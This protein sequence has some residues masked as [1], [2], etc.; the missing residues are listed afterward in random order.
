MIPLAFPVNMLHQ[1]VRRYR[2]KTKHEGYFTENFSVK[3][4]EIQN[5]KWCSILC[6]VHLLAILYFILMI[7]FAKVTYIFLSWLN[8]Q[9]Q[10][11]ELANVIVI[12]FIIGFIMF[13]LP[14]VPGVPVYI[15]GGIILASR[16]A[17]EPLGFWGG[18]VVAIFV[19]Y[20]LKLTAVCGQWSIGVWLGQSI[21]VQKMVGVDQVAIRAIE[22]ILRRPGL[23]LPKV[24]VLVGGPDWPTSVLCGILRIKLSQAVLGT[25]PCIVVATPCVLVGA[26]LLKAG[27][28]ST[29]GSWS[30]IAGATLMVASLGQGGAG[31][32][33]AYF[34]SQVAAEKGEELAKPRPEHRPIEELTKKEQAAV[35]A[36]ERAT[37]WDKVPLWRK[38]LLVISTTLQVGAWA[39]F[40]FQ[41]KTC[42]R[43]FSLT[44][45]IEDPYDKN[46]LE[47]DAVNIVKPMGWVALGM[48]AL[49]CV[50]F[51][52]FKM[53]AGAAG[54]NELSV[55][56]R[57]EVQEAEKIV[58]VPVEVEKIVEKVVEVPVKK[59]IEV[60]VPIE[61]DVEMGIAIEVPVE[62]IKIREVEKIVPQEV[63]VEK[64]VKE[65]VQV[66]VEKIGKEE[67][68]VEKIVEK[69]V[70]VPVEKVVMEELPME[71]SEVTS[72]PRYA[73]EEFDALERE[74]ATEKGQQD[75]S[76]SCE[77][78]DDPRASKDRQD[79][80]GYNSEP[81]MN[82]SRFVVNLSIWTWWRKSDE[83]ETKPAPLP[84][85]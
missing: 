19:G 80:G 72:A 43:P 30:A 47:G 75:S 14:P 65:E 57:Q 82:L 59:V 2:S 76:A 22:D 42:F 36:Y 16:A 49:A 4:K 55:Y 81:L 78:V 23:S 45:K 6:K 74:I 56:Q 21:S 67:V 64:I 9:L 3:L 63:I 73:Q 52:V 79:E 61:K 34:M 26:F 33:A 51:K 11:V 20:M 54:R 17:K 37:E 10:S 62:K 53:W 31:L 66:P 83:Y 8:G 68:V 60:E 18:V 13:M 50:L 70:E 71:P 40:V 69:L 5:W 28:D 24:A 12:F 44:S 48:F 1:M 77:A 58:D 38:R 35:D 85:A 39:A 84:H 25:M 7:G 27:D 41:D 15:T 46:G 32:A 29:G